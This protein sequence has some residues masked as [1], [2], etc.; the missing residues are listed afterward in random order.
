MFGPTKDL[1]SVNDNLP[2]EQQLWLVLA[3][4][5]KAGYLVVAAAVEHA[6][7]ELEARAK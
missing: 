4:A 2:V 6:L 7:H 3:W 1:E 5:K